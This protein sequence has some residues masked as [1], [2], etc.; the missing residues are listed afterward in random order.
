MGEAIRQACAQPLLIAEHIVPRI[1]RGRVRKHRIV[2]HSALLE[3]EQRVLD[4]ATI[5]ANAD[6]IP[7]E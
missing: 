3:V 2:S 6:L 4:S 7:R 5:P 1:W